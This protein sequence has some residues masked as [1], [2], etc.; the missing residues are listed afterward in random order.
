MSTTMRDLAE[1]FA[2]SQSRSRLVSILDGSDS[3]DCFDR[4]SAR[5]IKVA[6]EREL[7]RRYPCHDC[8]AP[9]EHEC[10]PEYGCDSSQRYR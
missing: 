1:A 5:R 7:V 10:Y 6:A 3:L 4:P 8:G 9:A 2:S